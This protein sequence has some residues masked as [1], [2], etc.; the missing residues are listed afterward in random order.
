MPPTANGKTLVATLAVYANALEGK[1]VHIVTVND[2]LA[3]R[4][5]VWMAPIYHALGL[6]VGCLQ[7]DA[8]YIYDPEVTDA[9]NGME[10]LRLVSRPEAYGADIT[11]GTNNEFG[12]FRVRSPR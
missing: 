6:S 2:Y 1:G 4:D 3:R 8:S 7:H 5:P 10:S 9:P 12:Y 11:Y